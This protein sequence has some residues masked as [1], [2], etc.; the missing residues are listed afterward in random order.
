MDHL[1]VTIVGVLGSLGEA[2]QCDDLSQKHIHNQVLITTAGF[3]RES[4]DELLHNYRSDDQNAVM[5]AYNILVNLAYIA[6]PKFYPYYVARWAQ[7][8]LHHKVATPGKLLSQIYGL[9]FILLTC[10]SCSIFDPQALYVSFAVVLCQDISSESILLGHRIGKMGMSMC[11]NLLN[12]NHSSTSELSSVH[13]LYYSHVGSLF[14]PI[15][16]S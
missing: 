9:Q 5:Q 10:N 1:L 15:Q 16:V 6:R 11:M 7:Y 3:E 4:N 14:E 8:C 13:L 12:Q 2:I